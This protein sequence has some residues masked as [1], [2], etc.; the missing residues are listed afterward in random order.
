MLMALPV[1]N[2]E[3]DVE[4]LLLAIPRAALSVAVSVEHINNDDVA[5][6]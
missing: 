3:D 5:C 1:L 6:F 4:K 2:L